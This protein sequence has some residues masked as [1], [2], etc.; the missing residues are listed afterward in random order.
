MLH[1]RN[2]TLPSP[3]SS[4]FTEQHRPPRIRETPLANG[5][6][7]TRKPTT[8]V[9]LA[10]K[11]SPRIHARAPK[12]IALINSEIELVEKRNKVKIWST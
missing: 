3:L 12:D 10:P 5:K 2:P 7:P 8:A 6:V 11:D 1:H 4:Y 9:K